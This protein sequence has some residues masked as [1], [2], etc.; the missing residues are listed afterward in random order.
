MSRA[1]PY[2]VAVEY[3]RTRDYLETLPAGRM[4]ALAITAL[5][6]SFSRAIFA[7]GDVDEPIAFALSAMRPSG[8]V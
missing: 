4:R 7:A 3:Q 2:D 1:T 6:E 5:E 8:A